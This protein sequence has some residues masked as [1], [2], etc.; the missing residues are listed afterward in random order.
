MRL[1]SKQ[2]IEVRGKKIGAAYPLICLPL[3]AKE[4]TSL[5][6]QAE[7]LIPLAPDLIEWRID[8]F[9]YA[10]DIDF[11]LQTLADLRAKIPSFPLILTCRIDIEGGIQKISPKKRLELIKTAI[12]T[13]IPDIVD[14]ELCNNSQ[15]VSTIL[16]AAA[17]YGIK[18]ILSFHDFEKTPQ[19]TVII[20]R[21]VRAQE[22]GAHI[23]KAAVMPN[24]QRD[25]L[26]LLNATLKARTEALQIPIIT[27]SMGKLGIVTRIAGGLFGS[28]ITF[29]AGK[30]ASSPGQIPIG[31]LRT[32]M[33]TM[34]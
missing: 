31:K 23:A 24:S 21:L 1:Q 3:V 33:A 2:I 10:E 22:M 29:A 16:N 34:Y 7:E 14:I 4:K 26:V 9:D 5:L 12:Q 18:V 32:A 15:F 17:R 13:G 19:E 27:M 6:N 25:V 8:S 28:D 11:C 30:E 20:N